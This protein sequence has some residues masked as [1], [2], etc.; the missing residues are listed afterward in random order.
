MKSEISA[1]IKINNASWYD[2]YIMNRNSKSKNY[3]G[4]IC[5]LNS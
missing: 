3:A 5:G 4:Y 2:V 1:D